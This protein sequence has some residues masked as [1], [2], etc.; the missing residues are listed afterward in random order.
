MEDRR[1]AAL[2]AVGLAIAFTLLGLLP[3]AAQAPAPD[4][5][6]DQAPDQAPATID[7]AAPLEISR[8]N[9]DL[10]I[11]GFLPLPPFAARPFGFAVCRP[12]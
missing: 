6:L 2:T 3:A 12:Q 5:A 10:P 7:S 4:L 8:G 1:K 9:F 11:F